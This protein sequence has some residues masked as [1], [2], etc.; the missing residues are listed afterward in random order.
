MR[1]FKTILLIGVAVYITFGFASCKVGRFVIYNASD[2]RD[3]KKF[4]YRTMH[5]PDKPFRFIE[6]NKKIEP[7]SIEID[8]RTTSFDTYLEQ[9]GTVAFLIIRNDT[10]LCEKYFKGYQEQNWVPSFSMGK[11][12]LSILIGCAIDDGLI[13][14]VKEPVSKYVPELTKNGYDKV[15]IEHLLNMTSGMKFNEGYL[16]PFGQ[17]ASFYYGKRLRQGIS[18][19]KLEQEPG[20]A[21]KYVS[22]SSQLLGL[23]L[24]RALK[25]KTITQYFEEK[26]WQPLGMQYDGTW[27]IDKKYNGLE[28]TFCCVNATAVDFAKI[29]RLMSHSGNWN[30][31]QIVSEKWV[32]E[33][34]QKDTT[35]GAVWNYLYQWWFP[36]KNGNDFLANGHLGQFIYGNA[37]KN[38][39][40][41]RLG[42][43]G[44]KVKSWSQFFISL[45]KE[46]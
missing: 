32:N 15:S 14:S 6:S 25:N 24:E 43:R 29:G 21:F 17:V 27:S 37:D 36:T 4:P 26:I 42:K 1:F 31:K 30:G 45:A 40:I 16:N 33:S 20:K 18:H 22:G 34:L 7:K 8:G 19:L 38:L 35:N 39:I 11:S 46:Y 44:G 28:K 12:F 13:L 41:V 23:V 9:N 10:V 5:K 2:I 3:Y